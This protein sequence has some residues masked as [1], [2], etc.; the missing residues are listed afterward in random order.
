MHYNSLGTLAIEQ[1]KLFAI[2]AHAAVGQKRKFT[3]EDYIVHPVR[4]AEMIKSLRQHTWEMV[5]AALLHDT[6]E[7]THVT[8][9]LIDYVFGTRVGGLVRALTNVDKSAGNRKHRLELNIQRLLMAPAE[10]K[11]IK[12]ADIYDNLYNV[13]E[14]DF[15]FARFFVPEKKRVMIEAL[16]GCSDPCL[17]GLTMIR[18]EEMELQIKKI[19][20]EQKE[21]ALAS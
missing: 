8:P 16:H 17:W 18:I 7:D 19:E 1:A 3:G 10:A 21:V 14:L 2:A 11:T 6:V 15:R 5:A 9:E 13:V 20:A 12:V 4:V